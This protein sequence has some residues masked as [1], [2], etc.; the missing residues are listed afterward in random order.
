VHII[1]SS[2]ENIISSAHKY[3]LRPVLRKHI[4]SYF[5]K[6]ISS[7]QINKLCPLHR[8]THYILHSEMHNISSSRKTH[9]ILFIYMHFSDKHN[10]SHH[11]HSV[12]HFSDKH[13]LFS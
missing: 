13:T 12:M 7:S 10:I 9:Y 3:T 2:Q 11:L 5:L 1:S 8:I 6:Y 4:I